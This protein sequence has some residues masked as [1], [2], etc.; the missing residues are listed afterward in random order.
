M[1]LIHAVAMMLLIGRRYFIYGL[2]DAE[3]VTFTNAFDIKVIQ[4][5]CIILA[6]FFDQR[7]LF[8]VL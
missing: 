3:K 1:P 6:L 7:L 8:V 2:I 5:D 4:Q